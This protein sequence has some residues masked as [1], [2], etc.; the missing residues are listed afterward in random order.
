[1]KPARVSRAGTCTFMNMGSC[2][3]VEVH[4]AEDQSI[5]ARTEALHP[6]LRN[7]SDKGN[8]AV[9]DDDDDAHEMIMVLVMMLIMVVM[10]VMMML[11]VMVRVRMVR[12]MMLCLMLML[13][14]M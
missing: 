8:A 7:T 2:I 11:M 5:L 6:R 9:G 12:M 3:L 10:M 4:G 1:M 14:L 13:M